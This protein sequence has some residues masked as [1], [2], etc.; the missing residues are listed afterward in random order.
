MLSVMAAHMER[1][2]LAATLCAALAGCGGSGPEPAPQPTPQTAATE[3]Q[4]VYAQDGCSSCHSIDGGSGTG[5][6]FKGL[7]GSTVELKGGRRAKAD[8]AYLRRAIVDP[9][10]EAVDGYPSGLMSASVRGL[11]LA[12]KPGDVRALV[13]YIGSLR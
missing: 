4:R 9:D 8:D 7:A 12:D 6:T 11:G 1:A 5:P 2:A 10:A 13:A 3:G